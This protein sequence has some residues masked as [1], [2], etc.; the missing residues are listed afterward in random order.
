M[1]L[2]RSPGG[3]L[4]QGRRKPFLVPAHKSLTKIECQ[5]LDA[6][7]QFMLKGD[8]L[9][10]R[11]SQNPLNYYF[12]KCLKTLKQNMQLT[13]TWATP[14][15]GDYEQ[16]EKLVRTQQWHL[17]SQIIAYMYGYMNSH[18]AQDKVPNHVVLTDFI[19]RWW[20]S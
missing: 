4:S 17:A 15:R 12:E 9:C 1:E 7:W 6:L 18:I 2:K 19:G 5:Q 10:G 16:A 3:L 20:D 11:D 8:L 13:D 14:L